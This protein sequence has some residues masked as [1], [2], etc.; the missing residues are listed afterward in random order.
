VKASLE[1]VN[2]VS[3]GLVCAAVFLLY[4]PLPDTPI[5]LGLIGVTFL[6]LLWEKI[7]SYLIVLVGLLAGVVF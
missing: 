7:P 3:A 2:A 6:V 1:G 4:H 5:N